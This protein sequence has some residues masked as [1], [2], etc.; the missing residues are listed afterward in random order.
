MPSLVLFGKR[1]PI[2]GDDLRVYAMVTVLLRLAQVG[3]SIAVAHHIFDQV[4]STRWSEEALIESLCRWEADQLDSL[5]AIFNAFLVSAIILSMVGAVY[6]TT[7]W[8]ISQ[9]G[10]PTDREDRAGPLT[11]VCQFHLTAIM[12]LRIVM[13]TLGI[14]IHS[15]LQEICLCVQIAAAISAQCD[16]VYYALFCFVVYTELIELILNGC[17]I[18]HV[19]ASS[20]LPKVMP[21]QLNSE[22]RWAIFCRCCCTVTSVLTCCLMGGPDAILGDYTDIAMLLS[23]FFNLHGALD[24]TQSDLVIGLLLVREVQEQ[25]IEEVREM[26]LNASKQDP[27]TEEIFPSFEKFDEHIDKED[28]SNVIHKFQDTHNL[29]DITYRLRRYDGGTHQWEPAVTFFLK[30]SNDTDKLTV[31]EGARF[32]KFS[33]AIYT[34]FMYSLN[35]PCTGLCSLCYTTTVRSCRKKKNRY[36]GEG[37][38]CRMHSTAFMKEAGITDE[39]EIVYACFVSDVVASPY[40]VVLDHDWKSIVIVIRGTESLE[41]VLTDLE[42]APSVFEEESGYEGE[43]RY[44]HA[45]ML[46]TCQWIVQDMKKRKTL[47]KLMDARSKFSNYRLRITGHSLGAGCAAILAMLLKPNYP[48]LRC[49]SFSP[50]GCTMSENAAKQCEDYLTSYVLDADVIPR[51]SLNALDNLR[52]DAVEMISRIKVRKTQVFDEYTHG[53]IRG[54]KKSSRL[55]R[56]I[57]KEGEIPDSEFV[58]EWKEYRALY[59][60]Q[61]LSRGLCVEIELFIP[62]KIVHLFNSKAPVQPPPSDPSL[63]GSKPKKQYQARWANRLDFREIRISSHFM[64]D[65]LPLA[66]LHGLE[67][68]AERF[69]LEL[70]LF[71]PKDNDQLVAQGVP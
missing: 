18:F 69:G 15:Q 10:T 11:C 58:R 30:Q 6:G 71:V 12:A 55:D 43:K 5:S 27:Q 42:I 66:V 64:D 33:L 9:R 22:N 47:D 52:Q 38:C 68:A 62:G 34:W 29:A 51:A 20:I 35:R 36:D 23:D 16:G 8:V 53:W 46:Q 44:V 2:A 70:P 56:L 31:A 61:K 48:N 49:H 41:D 40:A 26:V 45:G 25:R 7:V 14:Y 1:T 32:M 4:L 59:D 57:Y 54:D 17:T 21:R 19:T 39:S 37:Y 67:G 24:I 50:P 65:H 13:V 60:Q 63:L 3:A 28:L